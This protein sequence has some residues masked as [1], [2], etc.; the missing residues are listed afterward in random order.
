MLANDETI[1]SFSTVNQKLI[2]SMEQMKETVSILK[3]TKMK[4]LNLYQN[5]QVNAD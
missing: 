4:F 2:K 3:K 5:L 1:K